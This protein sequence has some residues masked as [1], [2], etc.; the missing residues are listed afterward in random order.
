MTTQIGVALIIGCVLDFIVAA[1]A[2]KR[3]GSFFGFF[4][5]GLFLSP[6]ISALC[7]LT[8]KAPQHP[9]AW[10][11]DPTRPGYLRWWDGA[12]WS[13]QWHPAA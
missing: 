9:P 1:A 3:G 10:L 11:L 4:L 5:L 8:L 12:A 7:L 2:T 13:D 6:V